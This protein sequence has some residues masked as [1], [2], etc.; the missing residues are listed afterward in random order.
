MAIAVF[1]LGLSEPAAQFDAIVFEVVSAL[2]TVGLSMGLT[3]D[4]S[5]IG[6]LIIVALMIVGRLGVLTFGLATAVPDE[7][8]EEEAD[9][10]L[11]V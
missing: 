2:G 10:D 1:L 11:A 8:R 5:A 7:T 9:N 3:T 4:L 6:K